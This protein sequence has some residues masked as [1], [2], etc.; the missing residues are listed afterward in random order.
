MVRCTNFETRERCPLSLTTPIYREFPRIRNKHLDFPNQVVIELTAACDQECVFCGRT[1]MERPKKTM[2]P[3]LFKKIVEEIARENPY[4]EVWPTFMGEALLHGELTFELIR[5]AR[6]VGC[7]KITLNSNGNRLTE[8]N[9]EGILTCGLDRFILSFDGFTKETYE[10]IRV[11]GNHEVLYTGANRLVE[12]WKRRGLS[13]PLLEMQF[14]IFDENEHEVE[15]FKEYWLSRGVVV[16]TRPKLY[17]N[18]VVEGGDHRVSTGIERSPCL[19]SLETMGIHW[20]GNVVACVVDCEG[21]F[22]AGNVGIKSLKE[23]WQGSLEWVREL[24]LQRRFR[25]LPEVCRKCTDWNVK[26]AHGFFPNDDMKRDYEAYVR[27]GRH[28]FQDHEL[29]PGDQAE[30]FTVDGD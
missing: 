1:Y 17:W 11:G 30:N 24:H 15:A 8:Q 14:S 18:G 28:F 19:W 27:L 13:K 2:R 21:K 6:E 5:Y 3:D 9:I 22:I 25:E 20:N 29:A 26:K 10:S 16:K 4:C 7:K 12:E 23:C